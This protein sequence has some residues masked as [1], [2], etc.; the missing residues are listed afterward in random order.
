[1]TEP[2]ITLFGP[3]FPFAYDDWLAHPDGI[4]SIPAE[5]HGAEVA[6]IGSGVSGLVCAYEL[7]RMGLKPVV[8]ESGQFGG[9]LRSQ[10]FE[11]ADGIIAEL[12][13][14][15]F[16]LSSQ[17]FWAYA[18]MLGLEGEDFP[19]PLTKAAG[20]TV[21]DIEGQTHYA[22]TAADLPQ[23]FQEVMQAWDAA[24]E[25]GAN[26]TA[27]KGSRLPELGMSAR[28]TIFSRPLKHFP[29]C[30]FITAKY[31]GK[32]GLVPADG[33][34]ISQIQCWKSCGSTRPSK[35]MISATSLVVPNK[36]RKGYGDNRQ[37]KWCTGQPEQHSRP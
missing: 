2:Q 5:A 29:N 32:S 7:M 22:E 34:L 19:N 8:Y 6:I 36:Y 21:I 30:P 3:D 26:F 31:S 23:I 25:E 11:G 17:C 28:S 33:I 9:R 35:T 4:G 27:L 12:G 14:M 13:G 10:P 15:R 18:D 20:S 37:K 24:L 1:M 16:P